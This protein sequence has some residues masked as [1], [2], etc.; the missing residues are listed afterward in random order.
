MSK[1]TE[2]VILAIAKKLVG[3]TGEGFRFISQKDYKGYHVVWMKKGKPG[4]LII[5]RLVKF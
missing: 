4:L 3:S 2:E 5:M 1:M